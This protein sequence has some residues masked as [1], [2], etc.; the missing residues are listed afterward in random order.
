MNTLPPALA[1]KY[2]VI[3]E[4]GQ[5]AYGIVWYGAAIF[6]LG[7]VSRPLIPAQT[8]WR[9]SGFPPARLGT[10]RRKKR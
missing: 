4:L 10:R 7:A 9:R 3:R 5:G 1:A 6:M 2:E 8:V